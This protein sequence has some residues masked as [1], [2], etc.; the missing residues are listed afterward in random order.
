MTISTD[1]FLRGHCF[2]R[3]P[4]REPCDHLTAASLAGPADA[5]GRRRAGKS[6]EAHVP[7]M[8]QELH[9][10]LEPAPAR[11]PCVRG[12]LFLS[13][14][15][16]DVALVLT[17]THPPRPSVRLRSAFTRASVRSFAPRAPAGA[18]SRR[19]ATFGATC[20]RPRPRAR[21]T[22]RVCPH[23]RPLHAELWCIGFHL[24]EPLRQ[25]ALRLEQ[26]A[27]RSRSG[28]LAIGPRARALRHAGAGRGAECVAVPVPHRVTHVRSR[29][30]PCVWPPPPR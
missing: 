20:A 26:G 9:P 3:A 13:A 24:T 17:R 10:A 22:D 27:S 15:P 25:P 7:A 6:Q 4:A 16:V 11:G 18:A 21:A 2:S 29:P 19:R 5:T 12:M 1:D 14:P 30:C 28:E 8:S 23:V